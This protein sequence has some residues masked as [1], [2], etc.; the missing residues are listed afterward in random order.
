MKTELKKYSDKVFITPISSASTA[1]IQ[2][3]SGPRSWK[4]E[5]WNKHVTISDCQSSITLHQMK[6][7]SDAEY[8]K[9]IKK[10]HNE[11]GKYIIHLET[12]K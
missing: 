1:Y 12:E 9:K 11:L 5:E 2:C 4:P 8:L 6:I 3:Y 10:L 7:E